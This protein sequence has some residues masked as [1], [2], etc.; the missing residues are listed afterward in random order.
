MTRNAPGRQDTEVARVVSIAP[1]NRVANAMWTFRAL[2]R[3]LGIEDNFDDVDG[4][5]SKQPAVQTDH[6]A[7]VFS[8]EP[9]Q[10]VRYLDTDRAARY[11]DAP[12]PILWNPADR[13][14]VFRAEQPGVQELADSLNRGLALLPEQLQRTPHAARVL[15]DLIFGNASNGEAPLSLRLSP[16]L[17]SEATR[18]VAWDNALRATDV[19]IVVR[20]SLAEGV[21]RELRALPP[22]AAAE[23]RLGLT[24]P[25]LRQVVS[26]LG[27]RN[28]PRDRFIEKI[29][30]TTRELLITLNLLF[31]GK[32]ADRLTANAV[33][34][35]FLRHESRQTGIAEADLFSKHPYFR[36]LNELSYLLGAEQWKT[37]E[38]LARMQVR[39]FLD[40]CYLRLSVASIMPPLTE[41]MTA[42]KFRYR[43]QWV[44]T[45]LPRLRRYGILDREDLTAWKTVE[46]PFRD[47][48]FVLLRQLGM[49]EFGRVYEALN[50]SNRH[51]PERIALKVDRL[52]VRPNRIQNT[53]ITL[54]TSRD[55][56]TSPHVIRI[57]DAG[58]LERLGL[59]YHVL[60]YI[61][62]DT[63]DVLTGVA[64]HE[65]SSV[66]RPG[67]GRE[68]FA[69]AEHEYLRTVRDAAGELW[70]K[71]R[72]TAPFTRSL[73]LHHVLDLFTSYLLWVEEVHHLNYAVND[74]K[75]GNLMI[76]R[77][78]QLKGIDMDSYS[79]VRSGHDLLPDFFFLAMALWMCLQFVQ[80]GSRPAQAG[81]DQPLRSPEGI[82][83]GLSDAWSFGEVSRTSKGRVGKEDVLD[84]LTDLISRSRSGVYA[85]DR[86]LFTADIDRLIRLKRRLVMKEIVLD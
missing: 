12:V 9:S 20:K 25:L 14:L 64:G 42:M 75:A 78:G 71:K 31:Q 33:G 29:E 82:R 70:R 1:W 15:D 65:H 16:D 13:S 69:A 52:G 43:G 41:V 53:E 62:G 54:Q 60:Q 21:L 26:Y 50:T 73:S 45:P 32:A 46:A 84:L 18:E 17:P 66:H 22:E 68:S 10:W 36:L 7:T 38:G 55:L 61:D 8:G 30:L 85:E 56:A 35:V 77:R 51:W 3:R 23:T 49:G 58:R 34:A 57:F 67:T 11:A 4:E 37:Y 19:C 74:L 72:V 44:S 79:P 6:S 2:L 24:W 47:V 63:V 39:E 27:Y 83:A 81:D 59:T 80:Q 5:D 40:G 86:G 48:G 28:Y 76:S